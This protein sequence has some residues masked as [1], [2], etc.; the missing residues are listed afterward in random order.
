MGS[1]ISQFQS[2]SQTASCTTTMQAQHH[3]L[4]LLL[5]SP[6]LASPLPQEGLESAQ[7]VI[8]LQPT[9]FENVF[10]GFPD[11]GQ[12][13]RVP[14][15]AGF[16]NIDIPHPP[17]I[18]LKDIFGA[19]KEQPL[20]PTGED[21]GLICKVFKSL[22]GQL[23]VFEDDVGVVRAP[24]YT[25]QGE[26]QGKYDNQ[27]E[28]YEE[29]VLPDGSVLRINKTLIHDTDEEGNGFFFQSSILHILKEDEEETE[30][31][32]DEIEDNAAEIEDDEEE[33][34]DNENSSPEE[35]D[36]LGLV[37]EDPSLNEVL[38]ERYPTASVEDLLD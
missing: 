20:N 19:N 35:D 15:F 8:L 28:S 34:E 22:E 25:E 23:G 32:E 2:H 5:L 29:K 30:D 38:D 27:T 18:E 21:C 24:V 37:D 14:S 17:Q 1:Q 10:A 3:H 6:V 4:L 36:E 33:I 26:S 7:P 11:F 9:S 31:I 13:E 16:D 12:F